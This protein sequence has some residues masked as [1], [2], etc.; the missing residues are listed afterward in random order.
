M[1]ADELVRRRPAPSLRGLVEHYDGYAF[2]DA[3]AGTHRGLPSRHLTVVLTLDR[4][5]EMAAMPD[6]L[7]GPAEF[8][9][10]IGGLHSSPARIRMGGPQSGVQLGLTPAGARAVFG[11]PAGELRSCVVPLADVLGPAADRLVARLREAQTWEARFSLLDEALT[12]RL[13]GHTGDARPEVVWAW[14]RLVTRRGS[15]PVTAIAAEVGWSRR[16]LTARFDQEFGLT[17]KVAARVLRFEASV[18]RLRAAPHARIADVAA[19]AGFADQAHMSR[20]WRDLA[21]C[22]P[23]R[24]I[25]EEFPY[26][27]AAAVLASADS[28]P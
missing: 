6:P 24:W 20:E 8:D 25:S 14:D 10:L 5:L 16:H 22:A 9:A 4:P 7:Q 12:R 13:D 21:G 17:P 27:Q 11:C 26:V 23:S 2:A 3:P 18:A 1:A 28:V 19:A 15:T